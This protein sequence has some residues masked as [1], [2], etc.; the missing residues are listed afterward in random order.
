MS[1]ARLALTIVYLAAVVT[2]LVLAFGVW[3][4]QAGAVGVR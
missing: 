3:A 2:L 1:R 4:G